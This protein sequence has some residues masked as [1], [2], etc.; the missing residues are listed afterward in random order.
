MTTRK[1]TRHDRPK[2]LD[3]KSAVR[4]VLIGT[5]KSVV[6]CVALDV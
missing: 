1:K 5:D 4:T 3:K 2:L 6:L